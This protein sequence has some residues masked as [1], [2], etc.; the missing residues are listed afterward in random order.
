MQLYQAT[1]R[2]ILQQAEAWTHDWLMETWVRKYARASERGWG[3]LHR[4]K[5]AI[6]QQ[7]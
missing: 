3:L 4:P 2:S 1:Y 6:F 7:M 5:G